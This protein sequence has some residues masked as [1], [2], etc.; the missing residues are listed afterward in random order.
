MLTPTLPEPSGSSRTDGSPRRNCGL[1]WVTAFL[2]IA[3]AI[4]TGL[5][6]VSANAATGRPI[7]AVQPAPAS[8]PP[9]IPAVIPA[10]C[11]SGGA[12]LWGHLATCGWPGAANTG[13]VLIDC[14]DRRLVRRGNGITPIVLAR[15]NETVRCADLRGP[16]EIKATG[17]TITNSR[18]AVKNG[19]RVDGNAAIIIEA[20][21]TA[22]IGHVAVAGHNQVHACIWHRG[23]RLKVKAVNCRGVHDAIFAWAVNSSA[24][25]GDN[26]SI[27]NSYFHDFSKATAGNSDDGFQTEGSTNGLIRHNTFRMPMNS[28]SAIAI[29]DSLRSSS[30]IT[31]RKNLIAGGGFAIY[32]EDYNPGDSA[33]GQL[34]SVLGFSV[35]GI[36]FD[37][38]SFSTAVSGCVG[39]YGA[40][41]T[42]PTWQPYQGGPTDGWNRLGNFV[43]ETGENIDNGN[44]QNNLQLCR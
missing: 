27:S 9:R 35:T 21:A 3:P 12:R 38:N 40:W 37:F 20:G 36:R 42:R 7:L 17:V 30:D 23:K 28:T 14:P 26:Y 18:V 44:P 29:W 5:G 2:L 24:T 22:T 1:G 4:L 11:Q 43:L 39:K 13:P 31:V 15:H 32:A 6:A 16:V 25:G 41:F 33:P 34:S 10:Y 8:R 19:V